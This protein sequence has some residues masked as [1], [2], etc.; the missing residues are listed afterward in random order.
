MN[1][2]RKKHIIKEVESKI[3]H[4]F[5]SISLAKKASHKMQITEDGA[6]G[7]GSLKV[8]M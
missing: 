3:I 8:V 1:Y 7:R 2:I 5:D 4:K 6:L